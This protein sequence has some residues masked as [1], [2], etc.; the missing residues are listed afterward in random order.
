MTLIGPRPG[1]TYLAG[2]PML[3]A[4][5]GGSR[6]APENTMAAFREA[7]ERWEA[8]ML[9]M[10]VRL[11]RDGEVVVIHDETVDR[12]TD[13]TGPVFSFTLEE[14][15]RLDA[16]YRFV[17]PEGRAAFRGKGVQVPRFEDVLT[18]FPHMRMNVETKETRV[19]VPLVEIVRRHH[20]E[21]RVLMAAE[22]ERWRA[23]VRGYP[24]PWGASRPQVYWFWMLHRLPGGGPYTPSADILQ[25]PETWRGRTIV[26]EAFVRAAHGRN[27]PVQVW[28]VDDVD[29]M[30]RLLAL[31]VDGIQSDRPDLLARVL[32]EVAGRPAPPGLRAP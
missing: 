3:V 15:R 26:T 7:V 29:D 5:R 32:V 1:R 24:G 21:S 23:P 14:L 30:R 22:H 17:D 8:D 4:H 10:D 12:T 6:L 18:A 11:T 25:V 20:A 27:L 2:A 31:G 13:G 16:G 19:A 9:E 28:T